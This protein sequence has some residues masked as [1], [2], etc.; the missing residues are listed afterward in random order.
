MV[1]PPV[2]CPKETTNRP[3]MKPFFHRFA[4]M[5]RQGLSLVLAIAL[6]LTPAIASKDK[7]SVETKPKSPGGS[8]LEGKVTGLD[9]KPVRGAAVAVRLLDGDTT[10]TSPPSDSKGRFRLDALP[11]GW[12]DLVVT[13]N[14]GVFLGDQAINLPPGTKVL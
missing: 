5:G 6:G 12:A 14:D 2:I 7:K 11:Y 13:T 9:G 10:W 1:R 8:R 3:L 4:A